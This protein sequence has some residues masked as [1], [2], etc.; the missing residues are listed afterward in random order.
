MLF[1][2]AICGVF[3]SLCVLPLEMLQLTWETGRIPRVR[4]VTE[5]GL[6]CA[7][8]AIAYAMQSTAREKLSP[9]WSTVVTVAVLTPIA[10]TGQYTRLRARLGAK[11]LKCAF[12][13]CVAAREGVLY[14]T[15]FA[16][17][18]CIYA[19]LLAH[20]IAYPLKLLSVG[21]CVPVRI[22]PLAMVCEIVKASLA[23]WCS[24]WLEGHTVNRS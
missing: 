8:G 12:V 3:G 5:L 19:P 20:L 9:P 14:G 13:A 21:C 10:V 2:R 6:S 1:T 16:L 18:S 24:A 15:L 17:D 4:P 11:Q 22:R 23:L 7:G